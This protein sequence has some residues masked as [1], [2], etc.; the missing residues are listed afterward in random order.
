MG[1]PYEFLTLSDQ[2]KQLRRQ[3]LDH[4]ASIA[5]YSAFAPALIFLLCRL[6][7]LVTRRASGGKSAA[8]AGYE[9]VPGSPVVKAARRGSGIAGVEASWSKVVWW[10]GDEVYFR[11]EN[12]GQKGEWVM[13]VSWTVWLLV[14]CVLGTG[15]GNVSHSSSHFTY[16]SIRYM[17][18]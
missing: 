3:S 4:Y 5:H 13:G 2:E 16:P 6:L 11:G 10:M 7:S 8:G 18:D 15:K 9:A 1:W 14:L 12:W 17:Q